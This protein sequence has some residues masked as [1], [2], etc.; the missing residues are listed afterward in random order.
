MYNELHNRVK[1]FLLMK[2]YSQEMKSISKVINIPFLN[3][4]K[5]LIIK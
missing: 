2:Y 5:F 3:K 1:F 4:T